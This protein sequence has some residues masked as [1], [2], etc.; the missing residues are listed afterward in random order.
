MLEDDGQI[1]NGRV[2][3]GHGHEVH[4]ISLHGLHYSV[5]YAVARESL[6][7]YARP[8]RIVEVLS[9]DSLYHVT[10]IV[11]RVVFCGAEQAFLQTKENRH[12]R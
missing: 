12:S 1:A 7:G 3:I 2:G 5:C 8:H 6:D 11:N 10:H 9:H 4:V